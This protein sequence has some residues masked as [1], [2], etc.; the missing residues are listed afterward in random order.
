M[1]FFVAVVIFVASRL[2]LK[3]QTDQGLTEA[4]VVCEVPVESITLGLLIASSPAGTPQADGDV[5][6]TAVA[7]VRC[8]I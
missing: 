5:G 1:R 3:Q 6:G 2:N 7:V 8:Y 4:G